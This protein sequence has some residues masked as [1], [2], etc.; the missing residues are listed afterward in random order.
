MH[1]SGVVRDV[2][3][4]ALDPIRPGPGL[5]V[6]ARLTRTGRQDAESIHAVRM[7]APHLFED[8]LRAE[9]PCKPFTHRHRAGRMSNGQD[10]PT[11]SP[12]TPMGYERF[13][14]VGSAEGL[15]GERLELRV[16]TEE[17]H[18]SDRGK[19]LG[20]LDSSRHEEGAF[21]CQRTMDE[22]RATPC[23][24]HRKLGFPCRRVCRPASWRERSTL[25]RSR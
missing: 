19:G 12:S 11:A 20:V 8:G 17:V 10:M 14:G 23:Y 4:L 9:V 22:V 25:T 2:E 7:N 13:A 6:E 21:T 5:K 16:A 1:R 24:R 15:Q 3:A 18:L